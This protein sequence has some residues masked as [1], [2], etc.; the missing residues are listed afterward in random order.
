MTF[1]K[2]LELGKKYEKIALEYLDYDSIEYTVGKFSE[3][4]FIVCK[5]NIEHKV[6]V[7]SDRLGFKT[8]NIC[9]EYECRG[10]AS[11]INKTTADYW[12]YFII[13]E[14]TDC[15]KI[16]VVELK[17]LVKNSRSVSGGDGKLAKMYLLKIS[18]LDKY[19]INSNK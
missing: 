19:K 6:E 8:G 4:D 17:E 2:D 15:Y 1:T 14:K 9:I 16:P 5:D 7:K 12:L 10:K 13:S 3:Y 11:G 18:S